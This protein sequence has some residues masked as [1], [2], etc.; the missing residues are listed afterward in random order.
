[1]FAWERKDVVWL[2][3]RSG[4]VLFPLFADSLAV[5]VYGSSRGFLSLLN[6]PYCFLQCSNFLQPVSQFLESSFYHA[7]TCQRRLTCLV[8]YSINYFL[9]AFRKDATWRQR[10]FKPS[11]C[12]FKEGVKKCCSRHVCNSFA[13]RV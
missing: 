1:M 10:F 3:G 11:E 6:K 5:S 7:T 13:Y 4:T 9:A 2:K 12:P 8:S